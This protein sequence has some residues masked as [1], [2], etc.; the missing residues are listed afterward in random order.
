MSNFPSGSMC[1]TLDQKCDGST[2]CLNGR[3]EEECS[4]L[5]KAAELHTVGFALFLCFFPLRFTVA[6]K[7]NNIKCFNLL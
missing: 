7:N 3:D 4:M 1:Y 6:T 5:I 2:T